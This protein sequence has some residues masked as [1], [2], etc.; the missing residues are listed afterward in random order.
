MLALTPRIRLIILHFV[1]A[2]FGYGIGDQFPL[3]RA[4]EQ[5]TRPPLFVVPSCSCYVLN[6]HCD[7]RVEV[8]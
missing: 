3:S 4:T 5:L 7:L 6:R 8:K 1:V 2:L